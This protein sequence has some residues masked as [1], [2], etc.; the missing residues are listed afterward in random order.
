MKKVRSHWVIFPCWVSAL[1]LLRCSD[2]VGWVQGE[3][4]DIKTC[5][6]YHE[7]FCSSTS[8]WR[9]T[10]SSGFTWKTTVKR[11][12]CYWLFTAALCAVSVNLLLQHLAWNGGRTPVTTTSI[13]IDIFPVSQLS[14]SFLYFSGKQSVG[15]SVARDRCRCTSCYTTN[16]VKSLKESQHTYSRL[17][18][19]SFLHPSTD[20]W[21]RHVTV[22][23]PAFWCQCASIH[24][25]GLLPDVLLLP[26][27]SLVFLT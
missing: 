2:T 6:T 26:P 27:A 11:E 10:G 21:W 12:T 24:H 22:F 14:L 16:D 4:S 15:I 5:V 7:R 1:T 3:A 18:A 17:V 19:S 8:G 9:G 23:A 25:A 13:S 20:F